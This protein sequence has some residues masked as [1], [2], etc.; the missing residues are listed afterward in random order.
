MKCFLI[1]LAFSLNFA[2]ELTIFGNATLGYYYVNIFVG[3]P[4]QMKSLI[5]DTGSHQTILPCEG[6]VQCRNHLN[7]IFATS[8][9]STFKYVDPSQY[10]LGWKCENGK[11]NNKCPFQ[12]GYTEGSSY[13]GFFAVDKFLFENEL[14]KDNVR[15]YD[16]VFGC[17]MKETGEFYSQEVDGIIGIGV[18]NQIEY[19]I[20]P[21]IIDTEILEGRM[22]KSFFSICIAHMNGIM[23]FG[24]QN[25]QLHLPGAKPTVL[26]SSRMNWG[27]QYNVELQSIMVLLKD[28]WK[29]SPI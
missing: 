27:T 9:S 16:H 19:A 21:T 14:M 24:G 23:K 4:P 1:S 13:S 18:L 17:A 15:N 12:Q 2:R 6:C 5:L 28:R 11:T 3:T 26:D 29:K 10:Y 25:K 8:Q 22:Q 7:A 20:P